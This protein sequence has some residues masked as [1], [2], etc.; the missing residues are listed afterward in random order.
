MNGHFLSL[1]GDTT[2][3][4]AE[5]VGILRSQSARIEMDDHDQRALSDSAA[6]DAALV[7]A[8]LKD[9]EKFEELVERYEAPLL[10][11]ILRISNL[12][13][14]DAQDVLQEVFINTWSNLNDYRSDMPF[15]SW[16]YRITHNTVIS[17]IRKHKSRGMGN[18]VELDESLY[19]IPSE[20]LGIEESL[21]HKQQAK[22]VRK[23][24]QMLPLPYREVLILRF[25]EGNDY[26]AISDI[27]RKPPG[28][29]ATLLNR[30][31]EMFKKHWERTSSSTPAL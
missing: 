15:K 9:L 20:E 25:L 14:A 30:G 19:E 10:R 3:A 31:K 18:T 1:Q 4:Y 27:L 29:V 24:L 21:D 6:E 28:T 12:N 17:T 16:I 5:V 11:Y 8:A 2:S 7:A 23:T 26:N 22:R 13:R